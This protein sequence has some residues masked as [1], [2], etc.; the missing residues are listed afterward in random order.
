M[1][2]VDFLGLGDGNHPMAARAARG[3]GVYG[4]QVYDFDR[5][6]GQ[7]LLSDEEAGLDPDVADVDA[8]LPLG[9]KSVAIFVLD[10]RSNKT[11]WLITIPERFQY[12]AAGDFLGETQWQ[13]FEN[14]IGRS[15]AAVNIV[16]TG[17]QVH[18]DIFWDG[19]KIEDW[20]KYPRAQ[21]RMY[22]ALLQPN[23]QVPIIVSGDIHLAQLLRKDCR[24][25]SSYQPL[26]EGKTSF[27]HKFCLVN[28]LILT[29]SKKSLLLA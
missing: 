10:V 3:M 7:Q 29:P 4:V 13:W 14:A 23:V 27:I 11:P 15:T 26:L 24:R 12:D 9:P 20:G 5:I 8:E 1:E 18:A 17:L 21:H 19:S 22:Q 6:A 16:V 25:G 2:F 28:T